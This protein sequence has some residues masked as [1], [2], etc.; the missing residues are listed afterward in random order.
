[1]ADRVTHFV[2]DACPDGHRTRRQCD[3]ASTES[4]GSLRCKRWAT[5][6]RVR[7]GKRPVHLCHSHARMYDAGTLY[8]WDVID[9]GSGVPRG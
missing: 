2:G 3:G 1:M 6:D 8:L 9:G 5:V 4:K 7:L